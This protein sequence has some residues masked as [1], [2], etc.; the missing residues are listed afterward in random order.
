MYKKYKS[1]TFEIKFKQILMAIFWIEKT[2]WHNKYTTWSVFFL[3][4]NIAT[5]S[6]EY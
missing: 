6:K 3:K 1:W 5:I 4:S 2:G